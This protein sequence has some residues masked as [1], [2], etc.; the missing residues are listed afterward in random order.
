MS[1]EEAGSGS[2][3]TSCRYSILNCM[4]TSTLHNGF[5]TRFY[6]PHSE[7]MVLLEQDRVIGHSWS[8]L[9]RHIQQDQ[10]KTS[11][12]TEPP[13][14]KSQQTMSKTPALKYDHFDWFPIHCLWIHWLAILQNISLLHSPRNQLTRLLVGVQS[15]R[16]WVVAGG[17][18]LGH[19]VSQA[20]FF[21][22]LWINGERSIHLKKSQF[23][24]ACA[25][26]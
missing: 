10:A 13:W 4:C 11:A 23:R 15:G 8:N 24:F 12:P 17:W 1:W 18:S 25:R 21:L 20:L 5:P 26:V 2:Q 3:C 19:K 22:L 7:Y 14:R 9:L 6:Y 16:A